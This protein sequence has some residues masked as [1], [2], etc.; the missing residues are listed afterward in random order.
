MRSGNK[1]Q[2]CRTNNYK[3]PSRR[4]GFTLIELMIVIVIIG[5]LGAIGIANY[6]SLQKKARYAAC[7]SNQRHVHEAAHIYAA[8]NVVGTQ[9]INVTILTAAT[10]ITQEVGE[11]PSSGNID[12]DDYAIDYNNGE[13]TSITCNILGVE[14]LYTP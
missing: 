9:N 11:C 4:G 12:F 5:I 13:I 2:H 8:D 1:K 3:R 10:L 7:I 14:H 6:V